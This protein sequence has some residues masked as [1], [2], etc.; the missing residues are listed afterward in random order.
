MMSNR[1]GDGLQKMQAAGGGFL[2]GESGGEEGREEGPRP[3]QSRR[4][5]GGETMLARA[6]STPLLSLA[7]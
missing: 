6:S 2:D 7:R 4:K 3:K 1:S 5:V